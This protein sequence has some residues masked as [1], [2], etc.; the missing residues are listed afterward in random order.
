MSSIEDEKRAVQRCLQSVLIP[1]NKWEVISSQWYVKWKTYVD[2][3]GEEGHDNLF[4]GPIDNLSLKGKYEDELRP[5]LVEGDD[6]ILL[7]HLAADLLFRKYTG[8]PRFIREIVNVGSVYNV[9]Y[10]VSLYRI[11]VEAYLCDKDSPHPVVNEAGKHIVRYFSKTARYNDVVDSLIQEF[12]ISSSRNGVRIWKKENVSDSLG[13][14]S[15][16]IEAS[17][18]VPT[19]SRSDDQNKGSA[20]SKEGSPAPSDRV[21]GGDSKRA[22][23]GRIMTTDATDWDGDWKYV[24]GSVDC[25][26]TEVQGDADTVHLIVEMAST[27]KPEWREWP[28]A[29][30]LDKWKGELRTGDVLD[31]CDKVQKKWYPS[32]VKEVSPQG[33]LSMHFMG[34]SPAFDEVIAARDVRDY[35][36]PLYVCTM[37]RRT[38]DIGDKVEYRCSPP[39]A[40]KTVWLPSTIC[41]VDSA[42]DR[43]KVRFSHGERLTALKKYMK[44]TPLQNLDDDAVKK[45]A[46][47]EGVTRDAEN[48]DIRYIWCDILGEDVCPA[49]T[50]VKATVTPASVANS[51]ASPSSG[52]GGGFAATLGNMISKPFQSVANRFDYSEKHIKGTTEVAG[53]VGLQNLGNTCFMNSILQCVSNTEPLTQLFLN[54]AFKSQINS[55]NPLGHGGK[56]AVAYGKLIKDMWSNA[57][58]KII[59]RDFKVTIGEFQPQFAGYDQQDSQEF[60][61]F[62]L[63]GLHVR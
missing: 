52:G 7:T 60:L 2:S 14:D 42:H 27:R 12:G 15:A 40:P 31:A 29:F 28:R 1:G 16:M 50:H 37:D 25:S 38:W 10:K 19:E 8:G 18:P 48:D 62:L 53:A 24:R 45:E 3:E 57:Y 5:G 58:S 41:E 26:I 13:G 51:L 59:P 32:V 22:R 44:N 63:D 46:D 20:G 55:D 33:D 9:I 43:V 36:R 30:L 11:R 56:L 54:D 17:T 6:Y 39:G 61:G 23:L 34:W 35:I 49:Q 4:P 21:E 47:A